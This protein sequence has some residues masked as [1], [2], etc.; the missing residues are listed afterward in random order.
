MTTAGT[1]NNFPFL[2]K[3][4]RPTA[5]KHSQVQNTFPSTSVHKSELVP[6]E[7]VLKHYSSYWNEDKIHKLALRLAEEAFFWWDSQNVEN[8]EKSL[9]PFV[10]AIYPNGHKFVQDNDPKH[11]APD[12]PM[13]GGERC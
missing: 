3:H 8:L 2:S 10:Q 6:I 13:D 5:R 9:L 4:M 12:P 7:Q 11:T 1:A